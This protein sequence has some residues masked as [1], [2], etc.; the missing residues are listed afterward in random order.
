MNIL[1]RLMIFLLIAVPVFATAIF[2]F[3]Q[4]APFGKNP[5]GER[6]ARVEKSPQYR[7]GS[8]QNASETPM[9]SDD[10]SYWDIAVKYFG[11]TDVQT[12]PPAPLPSVKTDVKQLVAN[13]DPN[14]PT[15][16][17]FGHSTYLLVLDGKTILV[18]P[19]ASER[20]SP[21]QFA[22]SARFAG[23]D[24]FHIADLPPLDLVLLTHD[25]YDH[26]DYESILQLKSKTKH[27]H[28]SL[29]VGE[30]LEHWG[31]L[32][33]AITE[34]DWWESGKL[35]DGT[36]GAITITAAPARHFSGRSIVR[37]KTLWSSFVIKSAKH[38]LYIGGDSGYD[39]H[40]KTIGE[41]FGPFDLAI[42]ECGQ[43]NTAWKLIHMMPEET[44]QAAQD[45]RANVLLPVHWGKFQLALH[46]W[47]E[48]IRRVTARATERGVSITTPMLGEPITIGGNTLPAAHWWE[49][50]R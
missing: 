44:V 49:N 23:T 2:L 14:Q 26:L 1:K 33:D 34:Y 29:G 12:N 35:F 42:L 15:L 3:M 8:F 31:V 46:S 30:H 38:T 47:D 4:Q 19:V 32:P 11:G 13:A 24:I 21:V 45:L 9:M 10:T 43:Y 36:S 18:D 48:S 40:F 25:H 28:T 16:V 17:W 20:P 7:D 39:T 22:G 41:K 5:T 6:L 37:N 27:F 50:V